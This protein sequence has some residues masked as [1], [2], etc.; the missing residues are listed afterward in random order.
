[1]TSHDTD[2]LLHFL[3]FAF[4]RV[5]VLTAFLRISCTICDVAL[6]SNGYAVHENRSHMKIPFVV[7]VKYK[8]IIMSLF[9]ILM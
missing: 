7:H 5:T 4:E 3:S 8:L 6:T 9:N 2:H 1:M